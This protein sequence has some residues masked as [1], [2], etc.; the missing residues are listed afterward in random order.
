MVCSGCG[1]TRLPDNK[2]CNECGYP[3][4]IT[5]NAISLSPAL[6]QKLTKIQT[7]LSKDLGQKILDQGDGVEGERRQV[8]IMFC[9]M[10]GSTPLTHEL[11]PEKTFVL[12]ERV[13]EIMVLKVYQ[14]QGAVNDI[15]GDGI[16]A[17]FGAQDALEDAP[18]RAIRASIAIHQGMAEFS[19][20]TKDD[21][22]IPI[23]LRIGISTGMVVIKSVH[24]DG[25]A[26]FT[27]V[28]DAI[29]IAARM[30]TLAE[31]GTTYVTEETY[32]LARGLFHFQPLGKKMI[33]GKEESIAVYKVQ[34]AKEDVYRPRLG[35]ERLIYSR[36][37]GRDAELSKL[38]LQV[39]KA[40]N[41]EGSVVN[42]IGEAGIGKSRLLAE[43][44]NREVMKR[45][46]VLEGRA[47]SIG[48]NLSFHPIID[49]LKQWADIRN[50]DRE[51]KAFDKLQVAVKRLFHEEYNEVLP[52]VATLMG[53]KLSGIHAQRTKE[54]E[55]EALKSLILKSVRDLLVKA[56][57]L[58]PLV[59]VID[60]LHWADTS[61]VELLESLFRLA[62]AHRMVFI[63]LFRPGYQE[64]GDFLVES[65]KDRQV[66][67]YFE[68]VLEP[69]PE[70][71][72]EALIG[73]MLNLRE[74]QRA[75][76]NRIVE[77]TGGN[78]FFIEEVV[79]SLIDEQVILTKGG[80][81][82]L[83]DKA[84]TISIPNTIEALLMAR[85]DRLEDQ[86]RDLVKEASVIGRSFFY[87]ILAKVASKIENIEARLTYL[88]EIQL[89]LERLRM[90]E[91][92]YLFKQA[93]AQEVAYESI[94]PLKRKELHL[95]VARS[96]EKVFEERL[97]EFY[98]MLAYHYCQAESLEEAEDCLIKA[99]EEALRS[100]ASD[101]ALHYYEE[102]LQLYMK[103]SGKD[104]H[105]E[106]VA[107]LEKNIALAL[108]NRGQHPEAIKY[109]D[110]VLDYYWRKLPKNQVFV[111]VDLLSSFVH[112]LVA[113]YLPFLKF[114][115]T[116]TERDIEI[117]DLFFKKTNSV[118][119]TNAKRFFIEYFYLFRFI[120]SFD[121]RKLK[122]GIGIFVV[123][124]ALF[125][126]SG[127]S[128]ALGK[129]V[130][131][132]VR[133]R[134]KN[135][136]V[137]NHLMYEICETVH[138]FLGGNWKALKDYDDELVEHNCRIGEIYNASQYLFWIG[139]GTI[140]LGSFDKARVI[141]KRL[142]DL[143]EV[144]GN[145]LSEVFK[146]EVSTMLLIESGEL[147]EAMVESE[148]GIV[149]GQKARSH[150]W[151]GF[152]TFQAWIHI[153]RGS[154]QKAQECLEQADR[155]RFETETAP[156]Q[157][158]YDFKTRLEFDLYR[159]R[160][161][162]KSGNREEMEQFQREA[163]KSVR[164][165]ARVAR[166]VAYHRTDSYRLT[167][168]YYWTI[169]EPKKAL[170]WWQKSVYEGER[171]GARPQL[172]RLYFEVGRCLLE[173]KAQYKK[174]DNLNGEAYLWKARAL[175]EAMKMK[176]Y[177]EEID[178]VA[179]MRDL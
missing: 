102:A 42:I 90:G 107:M 10:K 12:M 134:V 71:M 41:G 30:E 29:N 173:E 40:I 124:S 34:S 132:A 72:S 23:L 36:M 28:G 1:K 157:L 111:A 144:Y 112:F 115:K 66:K 26:W 127:I 152:H 48:K 2:Y 130:L 155:I 16:L 9:D 65:L 103:K 100:A 116:P 165:L 167:G 161:S 104:A 11:G 143:Y 74:L 51:A 32:R 63:N 64:T 33:K 117:V 81:F 25:R 162:T 150:F 67:Y 171:L 43:L 35:S 164:S 170:G 31:P 86:T 93:L 7:N 21:F 140:C 96:I 119:L 20:K 27:L 177:L 118:S 5:E 137:I 47:I 61:S 54:I 18:Q 84:A 89:I 83:T 94:L 15:R 39:M 75:F 121:L 82:H 123:S 91:L 101:E 159:L 108:Y 131:D 139:L 76:V 73:N 147:D 13:L 178:R 70:K 87:R 57:E 129:K 78:P 135:N 59:I 176:T 146:Y 3:F 88:Q 53:L 62:E 98:G 113:L 142:H 17:L 6:D 163:I 141:V 138:L 153:I 79:R 128:F 37:V 60:D 114:R 49:L 44:K 169:N 22:R 56:T 125:A 80:R 69:L 122:E 97:H 168:A 8:T 105:P 45:V 174:L 68:M 55:G 99:G 175:Y 50:D 19:E 106:K 126:Y 95:A 133:N 14:F 154:T 58:S 166:K 109:F 85:I 156:F 46:T 172:A 149:F 136:D 148:K 38:E 145:S 179:A 77:R 158:S 151:W 120:I 24:T 92:E 52:F 4:P 110:K 160:E